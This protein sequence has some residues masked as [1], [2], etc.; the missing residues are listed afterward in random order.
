[1]T[2][3]SLENLTT[4]QL[5]ELLAKRKRKEREEAKQKRLAYE[6][7]RNDLVITQSQ[8]A[9]RL[10][11][12]LKEFKTRA[13]EELAIFYNEMQQYG[14][15][16]KEG[17]GNFQLVDEESRFK[18]L[19]ASQVRSGFDE[20]AEL[21]ESKLKAFLETT[22]KKR[23]LGLHD[24]I[25]SLLERNSVSG[26]FDIR[27][28]GRLMEMEDKFDD[29]NWNEAI[30]LFKESYQ[31]QGTSTYVRFYERDSENQGWKLINLNM[32]SV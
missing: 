9:I 26:D 21:A 27:L 5:E 20:R 25:M 29:P 32:A 19:F 13:F 3:E 22:V 15:V 31:E 2:T 23:D 17:K 12:M 16:K 7:R 1:M 24:L 28:L 14:D 4:E 6:K 11:D 10:R 18:I 30:R 8:V